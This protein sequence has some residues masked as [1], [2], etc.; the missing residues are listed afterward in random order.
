MV[1]LAAVI[2]VATNLTAASATASPAILSADL[3]G[4]PIPLEAV[5]DY[6]CHDL[7]Y[8][9]LHCYGDALSLEASFAAGRLELRAQGG[10]SALAALQYVK[11]FDLSGFAG[12]YVVLSADYNNLGVIGWNDKVSSFIGVNNLT[13]GLWIDPYLSG[14]GLIR[15]CN[16]YAAELS[17][18]YNNKFSSAERR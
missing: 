8:P 4:A 12:Q 18:T 17:A 15:C 3:D 14:A 1:A 9:Q 7:D 5:G 16:Q 6:Y 2:G 13:F 11:L 10:E